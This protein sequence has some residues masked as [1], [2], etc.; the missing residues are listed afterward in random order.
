LGTLDWP[1]GL[2]TVADVVT[3][4]TSFVTGDDTGGGLGRLPGDALAATSIPATLAAWAAAALRAGRRSPLAKVKEPIDQFLR[5]VWKHGVEDVSRALARRS[6][7]GAEAEPVLHSLP[8]G[9]IM[10]TRGRATWRAADYDRIATQIMP[11]IAKE[12]RSVLELTDAECRALALAEARALATRPC[13][14]PRCMRIV[15]CR[16][17]EARGKLCNGCKVSRYCCREC[18]VA[19]WRAHKGV[20][21]ELAAER[22]AAAQA[23]EE[24]A[25]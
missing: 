16:E 25:S 22:E 18:Q 2:Q 7:E 17:R 23:D 5:A 12:M 10:A 19:G 13:A 11:S 8:G 21:G 3:R 20:C 4:L 14:N 6:G 24:G 1:P 15:G 9:D